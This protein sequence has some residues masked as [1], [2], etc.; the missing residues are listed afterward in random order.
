M[1]FG[2]LEFVITS[3]LPR[4]WIA[5]ISARPLPRNKEEEGGAETRAEIR[6]EIKRFKLKICQP[7]KK[8]L[9]KIPVLRILKFSRQGA[10]SSP[11]KFKYFENVDFA[12]TFFASELF[13]IPLP[14]F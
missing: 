14:I 13:K 4:T 5:S 6:T 1:L 8:V 2:N 11:R 9:R 3:N 7:K 10:F 12:N